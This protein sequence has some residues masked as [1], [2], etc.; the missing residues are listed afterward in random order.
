[1]QSLKLH[2]HT[3]ALTSLI[4]FFNETGTAHLIAPSGFKVTI[5]AGLVAGSTRWLYKRQGRVKQE[6]PLLP[7]QRRAGQWRRWLATALVILSISGYTFLS[8]GGPAATRAGI[9][10]ILLVI[11]PRLGRIYNIY[12]ALA[13][14]AFLMSLLDPFVLWE[15]GFQLSMLGTLGI[16]VLTP[17][18]LRLFHPI[19]RLPFVH[20]V[21]ETVAV[22]LA[23]QVATLPIIA[24][25][26]QQVSFIA[27]LTNLLTVPLLGAILV[28]GTV[29]CV[30]GAISI[31]LGMLCGLITWP[32][33]WYVDKVVSWGAILPGAFATVNNLDARLA[34]CYYALLILVLSAALHRWPVQRQ[35]H[36]VN[37]APPL[38][39]RPI[40][41]V[42]R[43]A[44]VIIVILAS[45]VSVAAA[46]PN[47]Q[48]TITLLNVGPAG[49]PAQGEAILI[50]TA[51]GR[52]AFI[53][54]GADA[55]SLSQE[56]D[57]RLPFW[58]RSIDTVILTTSRQD[59]IV[60]SQDIISRFQVGEV[61]D[62]GMLH[63]STGY[64][65]WR[66]TVS[67]RSLPYLQAR[68]GASVSLGIQVTLQVLWPPSP[69]HK[70]SNEEL[71]NALVVRL[72]AP[73]F[74]M[75]F[76]GAAAL[77][78]YALNGILSEI[79]P[80]YLRAD[81]VQVVGELGKA[82][83]T[84][85]SNVLQRAHPS[86]LMITPTALS[87]KLRKAGVTSTILPPQFVGASWQV[88]QTAQAGT[89]EIDSS[90]SGWNVKAE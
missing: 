26:F 24:F 40:R 27:P 21:M 86:L 81:V 79:N 5:L 57:S 76:L 12:T 65:L 45:G 8:G 49:K 74:N 69:L 9:M 61:L 77:S 22:T 80:G 10:G 48:L 51:D 18:F 58:Q 82:F 59:H 47:Q 7:A 63:P 44:A 23:A 42:L 89:M 6:K 30:A 56:L 11:A 53:D 68:E 15:A 35:P 36:E 13:L 34:W 37:A 70:G 33:L 43:Y 28:L 62:A 41:P 78:K 73:H 88:I 60:G 64:A 85:L 2:L 50:H 71:D 29:V 19:E 90:I 84:E 3:P 55:A 87:P 16:V 39:S 1:M 38:L 72:A 14:A 66:R 52:T 20:P 67:D 75:L 32:L 46:Q 17:L 83:P 4:K 31:Q 25:T 54:G